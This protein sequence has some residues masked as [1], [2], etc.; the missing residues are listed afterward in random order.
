MPVYIV[1]FSHLQQSLVLLSAYSKQNTSVGNTPSTVIVLKGEGSRERFST[2]TKCHW[3]L[4]NV[5]VGCQQIYSSLR[6]V[7]YSQK[8]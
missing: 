1:L 2:N 4:S 6:R 7:S 3:L 8:T 5:M